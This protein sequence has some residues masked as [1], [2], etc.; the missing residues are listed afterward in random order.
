MS[1]SC[2]CS[3]HFG[4][5]HRLVDGHEQDGGR[6]KAAADGDPDWPVGEE[7]PGAEIRW[8]KLAELHGSEMHTRPR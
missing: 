4:I 7:E 1:C 3:L 6:G 8:A 2:S 5:K